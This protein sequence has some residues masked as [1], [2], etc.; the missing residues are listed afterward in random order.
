[1][2]WTRRRATLPRFP[3]ASGVVVM[4]FLYQFIAAPQ[5]DCSII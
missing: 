4:V 5:R 2:V 1:M 3:T